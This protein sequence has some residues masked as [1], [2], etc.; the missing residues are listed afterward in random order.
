MLSIDLHIIMYISVAEGELIIASVRDLHNKTK[1]TYQ[2]L[3]TIQNIYQP[4]Q[5]NLYP[6]T[7]MGKI[8]AIMCPEI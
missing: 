8:I 7:P 4:H 3:T 5:Q 1:A 2:T 6:N